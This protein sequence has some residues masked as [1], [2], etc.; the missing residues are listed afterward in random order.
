M[1]TPVRK[2]SAQHTSLFSPIRYYPS[3]LPDLNPFFP[4]HW[5]NEFELNFICSGSGS[6][7]YNGLQYYPEAG[8]IFIFQPNQTH[9]MSTVGAKKILYDTLLFNSRVFGSLDENG[10]HAVISPLISGEATI[11]MPINQNSTGYDVMKPIV[12][13]IFAAAK[14]NDTASEILVKGELHRLFYCLHIYGHISYCKSNTSS[15]EARLHPVLEFIDQHY[16]EDLTVDRLAQLIP[17]STSYFM[18]CFKRITGTSIVTYINQVRISNACKMLV[19][20]NEQV[21]RIALA[22]GF[23]NLSNFNRQF[24]K[25]TGHSPTNYRIIYASSVNSSA[26]D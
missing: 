2:E 17:L 18:T 23:D 8:D 14:K 11:R 25:H 20:S 3:A 4:P 7:Y 9:G 16:A 10:N 6:F 21:L 24:K 26:E 1:A 19:N 12:E 5:H 13:S 15:D 22:C